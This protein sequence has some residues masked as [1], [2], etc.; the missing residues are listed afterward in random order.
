MGLGLSIT[1]LGIATAGREIGSDLMKAG[2]VLAKNDF[3][4]RTVLEAG[5]VG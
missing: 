5:E 1:S 3:F 4:A 2:E